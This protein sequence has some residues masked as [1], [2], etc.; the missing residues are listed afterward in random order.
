MREGFITYIHRHG[1]HNHGNI[2]PVK[3]DILDEAIGDKAGPHEVDKV[4]VQS[5]VDDGEED[6]LGMVPVVV[7]DDVSLRDLE[8]GGDPDARD[9]D[10]DEQDQYEDA[11]FEA[12]DERSVQGDEGDAVDDD[13]QGA[14]D[15]KCPDENCVA[16]MS[17]P[18]YSHP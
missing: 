16:P 9:G 14:V 3:P 8:L 17:A 12:A 18:E 11:P 2:I 4:Q 1:Y 15:L 5:Y 7:D 13:L 10:V 6:L